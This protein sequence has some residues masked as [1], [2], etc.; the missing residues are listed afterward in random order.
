MTGKS[1]K[2]VNPHLRQARPFDNVG[3]QH[4]VVQAV[5]NLGYNVP[6]AATF[7][8]RLQHV[9]FGL[10]A[11]DEFAA[12]AAWLGRCR[13]VHR[14]QQESV[15]SI[16]KTPISKIPDLLAVVD[17]KGSQQA[18]LIEVKT[19]ETHS[20]SATVEYLDGM[21]EYAEAVG[22][23]LLMAWK[24]RNVGQW[25]LFGPEHFVTT[26]T[27]LRIDIANA[28]MHNL[29][30]GVF[31]DFSI[32]ACDGTGFSINMKRISEKIRVKAG[33]KANYRVEDAWWHGANGQ[34][35]PKPSVAEI[36]MIFAA[37]QLTTRVEDEH[38]VQSWAATGLTL[39]QTVLRVLVGFGVNKGHRIHWRNVVEDLRNII[40]RDELEAELAKC[41]GTSVRYILHVMPKEWPAYLPEDW[42]RPDKR[43]KG[44]VAESRPGGTTAR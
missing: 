41:F 24:P 39:A 14:M 10:S 20:L 36:G 8:K 22:L 23:P 38:I 13:L 43:C 6:D 16:G 32:E 44:T 28:F 27:K 11:E 17:H 1:R 18:I 40:S 25:L 21:R 42:G 29:M 4:R 9:E 15:T 34:R 35:L 26:G 30:G 2:H 37:S 7:V 3:L 5:Q 31:G 19:S 33:H 12:I